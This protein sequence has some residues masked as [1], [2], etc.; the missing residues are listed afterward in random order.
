MECGKSR[1]IISFEITIILMPAVN[2]SKVSYLICPTLPVCCILIFIVIDKSPILIL[3][4]KCFETDL[5]IR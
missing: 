3:E 2:D 4:F 1:D 5:S